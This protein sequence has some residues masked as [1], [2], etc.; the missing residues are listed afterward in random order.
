[1]QRPQKTAQAGCPCEGMVETESNREACSIAL[2]ET[3]RRDGAEDLLERI[4]D[5]NNL[6]KAYLKVKRNGGA[7]GVDGM[8]VSEMLPYLKEHR[9]ELLTALRNGW[10]KP[11]AVRR[12]EIPKPDG[13]VRKLGVPTVIDRMIQQAVVQVL[14][15]MY[16]PLFSDS[17]YGFRPKRSAHQAISKALEY[18]EQGYRY[19]VDLDL[20]KYFDTVNHAILIGMLREQIRDERVVKLIHKFLRSGVLEH[21]LVSPTREGTPQGGN[22]SPLLSN[23][24]LTAFD[25]LLESRGHKFVRYAD[26]CN[27]YVKSRRAAERVMASCVKFLE[28]TLKLTVNQTKSQVGSPLKLKFLGFSLYKTGRKAG[29]RPH[30]KSIKRFKDKIRELT[31]RKQARSV[32]LILKRLKRYTTGWLG[33]YSIADMESHMKRLTEWVRRRIRQIY[34]KQWKKIKTKHD[35]LVRLGIN[36]SKA[37]EWANSRK[38]Y[39]RIAD[40]HILHMSL[41]NEYLASV[42]YDDILHRYKVLHSNY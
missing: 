32:E 19:V 3:D 42:G 10:Y 39:W 33:Y 21:G 34:W 5:R 22:L 38:A 30:Q 23:I 29:I 1:M 12:V 8:T 15:P 14:Q 37:W 27:I 2:T 7:A 28:G 25:R 17:S 6:N 41:T 26:D 24:Y 35:N 16:E 40:S 18:Y 13:G 20:A 11:Q 31:S 9:E 36:N 4:L